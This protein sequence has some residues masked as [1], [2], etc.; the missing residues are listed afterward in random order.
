[1]PDWLTKPTGP[2][3]SSPIWSDDAKL[4][5]SPVWRLTTP[6]Q[7]GPH[8]T[9]PWVSA[10]SMSSCS[11]RAPASPTSRNPAVNITT[12]RTP[13]SP[14]SRSA[15]AANESRTVMTARSGVSGRWASDA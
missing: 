5:I 9:M 12:A 15:S 11:R 7:L 2:G 14:Q 13:R 1:M 3:G 10:I 4:A 6:M 8:R